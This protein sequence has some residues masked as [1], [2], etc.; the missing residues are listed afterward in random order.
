MNTVTRRGFVGA[1]AVGASTLAN[2]SALAQSDGPL[3]VGVIGC[4]WFGNELI[5]NAHQVGGV[6]VI[7]VCDVDSEQSKKTM[8]N[9]ERLSGSRPKAFKHYEELLDLSDLQAVFIAT[10]PHWHAL[11]FIAACEKG[12]PI[13]CEKPLAYD[14]REGRAMVNA[15]KKAGNIVQMGFQRR[16]V[17]PF[18]VV[19]E[20]LQ[21]GAPGK[22]V[23]VDANIHYK[24]GVQD[25]T[26]QD[27]P[28]TLDWDL[29]CGPAPKLPYSPAIGHFNWRLEKTTGHGHLVDWGIHYIDA[30]RMMLDLGMPKSIHAA[31][32]LYQLDGKI[33][34]P[35]TLCVHFEFDECPVVWRHRLWGAAE[36]TPETNIGVTLFCENETIFVDDKKVVIVPNQRNAE[37]QTITP[38][39]GSSGVAHMAEFLTSLKANKPAPCSPEVAYQSTGTVQLGMIAYETNNRV[40]WDAKSENIT[41]REAAQALLKREYRAPYKHPYTG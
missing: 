3:R 24:A 39:Q 41:N 26:P 33:T 6:Q 2:F 38:E 35:D 12:L 28:K 21:Q 4:G 8:D 11:P 23:Q 9:V 20:R 36:Y 19:K 30:T 37:R 13:Y 40:D 14:L 7:A 5:K 22:V 32:G 18:H 16:Q 29:W 1:A 31:G 34:T 15:H 25:T 10:P 17:A 27:P